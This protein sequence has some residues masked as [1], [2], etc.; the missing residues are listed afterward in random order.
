MKKFIKMMLILSFFALAL[1]GCNLLGNDDDDDDDSSSGSSSGRDVY[2]SWQNID[3]PKTEV[4]TLS[5]SAAN[6]LTTNTSSTPY[7]EEL[8]GTIVY[9]DNSSPKSY[10][11]TLT[12]GRKKETETSDWVTFDVSGYDKQKGNYTVSGTTLT[13]TDDDGDSTDY[14]KL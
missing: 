1:T 8:S 11:I 7:K 9:D 10:T 4:L 5:E 2:G 13:V 3:V 6:L 14:T 12:S